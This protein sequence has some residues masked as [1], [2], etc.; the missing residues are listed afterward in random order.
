[1]T[2]ELLNLVYKLKES[3]SKD[4]EILKLEELEN[5]MNNSLE[6]AKLAS[7]KENAS[8]NYNFALNHF[9]KDS[10]EVEIA[11]KKLYEAKKELDLNPL[12]V[13]YVNQYKIVRDFYNRINEILFSIINKDK[14]EGCSK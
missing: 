11:Q 12:V 13:E 6:V 1:M 3:L 10:E 5:K 7:I 8:D 4:E 2:E 9:K 14:C